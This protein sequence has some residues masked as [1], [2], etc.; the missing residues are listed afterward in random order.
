VTD[1]QQ[2]QRSADDVS[3]AAAAAAAAAA[4]VVDLPLSRYHYEAH[5]AAKVDTHTSL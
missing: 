3:D 4:I 1:E 2:R 5:A